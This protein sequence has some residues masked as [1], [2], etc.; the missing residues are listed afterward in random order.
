MAW[1]RALLRLLSLSLILLLMY[2]SAWLVSI[3]LPR[4]LKQRSRMARFYFRLILV[5]FG[6][7]VETRIEPGLWPDAGALIL[8][9]HVSYLDIFILG[10]VAPLGFVAKKEISDWPIV[11]FLVDHFNTIFVDRSSVES[12]LSVIRS[13]AERKDE[14]S[15]C[16]FP[17][18]TT[19]SKPY[20]DQS[21]WYDGQYSLTK[22][23]G[24]QVYT[25]HLQ[26]EDHESLAWIDDMS[27]MPHLLLTLKRKK[28][29]V[30]L[31]AKSYQP[32]QQTLRLEASAIRYQINRHSEQAQRILAST[33][34]ALDAEQSE[35]IQLPE[36]F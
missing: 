18:G 27:L 19:S 12:R 10:S 28:T 22:R 17:Q 30:V 25:A 9:N 32:S 23:A 31:V 15:Y 21:A 35:M 8:A 5:C 26:Y 24:M 20:V 16:V 14:L 4:S 2:L 7:R 33:F 34:K 13:I 36:T 6:L 3:L 11:G 29:R 1:M